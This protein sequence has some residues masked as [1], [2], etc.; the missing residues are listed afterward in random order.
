MMYVYIHR[1]QE[2]CILQD[3]N[4]LMWRHCPTYAISDLHSFKNIFKNSSSNIV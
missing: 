3:V 1:K 4:I 2:Y